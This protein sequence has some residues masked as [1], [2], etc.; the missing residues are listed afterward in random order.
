M[1]RAGREQSAPLGSTGCAHSLYGSH[2]IRTPLD[3]LYSYSGPLA[4]R[5]NCVDAVEVKGFQ[6]G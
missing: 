4:Q 3:M 2:G 5:D 6:A 1:S